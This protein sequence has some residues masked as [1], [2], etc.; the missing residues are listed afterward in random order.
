MRGLLIVVPLGG[1]IVAG[2]FLANSSL[3][4]LHYVTVEGTSRLSP[5]EVLSA[6]SVRQGTSLVRLDPAAVAHR[7]EHLRPVADVQVHRRWPHGLVIRV[8][9]RRPAGVVVSGGTAELLD[10]DGVAFA[11]VAKPPAGLVRVEVSSPVPGAGEAVAR[12]A[13]RVLSELPARVRAH[14]ATVS[15]P[16]S[17]AV[18]VKLVDGRTVIWGSAADAATKAAVLRTLM[19]RTARVYDVSVPTVAVTR[20]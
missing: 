3:F 16:S 13:M 12:T 6:A 10:A 1:L 5:T 9:E 2:W 14:V 8:V 7:V 15:A 18:S 4:A 11:R 17:Y 20:G 19:H